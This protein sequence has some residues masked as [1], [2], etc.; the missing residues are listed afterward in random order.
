MVS[1][2]NF[3]SVV[4]IMGVL[5]FLFQ[6]SMVIRDSQSQYG[7]NTDYTQKQPDG[8][9]AWNGETM[10]MDSLTE[11][12]PDYVLYLGTA[13]G[14]MH[15]QVSSWCSYTKRNLICMQNVMDCPENPGKIPSIV[16]LESE[17][18]A[19]GDAL[20]RIESWEQQG[21][22]IIFGSLDDA[23]AIG[24]NDR[25]KALLGIQ[26]VRKNET[27]L[28]GVRLFPEFLLGGGT[29]YAASTKEEQRERQDMQLTVP[30][31][32]VGTG[33]K[34]YMTGIFEDKEMKDFGGSLENEELPALIW[35]NSP[36]KGFVFAVCG[37]YMKD[38]TAI[39]I[40]DGM[41]SDI[42][43]Y[44]LYPVVN[45]QNLSV[46]DF[47]EFANENDDAMQKN[48]SRSATVAERDIIWPAFVALADQSKMKITC[49]M[50][51]ELDYADD[52]DPQENQLVFYLKQMKEI[53]AEAGLALNSVTDISLA[54]KLAKDEKFWS[55]QKCDYRFGAAY[56]EFA[57][58]EDVVANQDTAPIA[59]VGTVTCEYTKNQPLV[60][61]CS[62]AV[63]LQMATSDGVDY[64]YRDDLRMRSV[65]SALAYTNVM[66]NMQKI[67]W[68]EH[69][70]DSWEIVQ[71]RFSSNL[72][73]FWKPFEA[74]S[75]TTLSE[76]D[77][78]TRSL[79]NMNYSDTRTENDITL[80]VSGVK[81][82]GWFILRT[83]GEEIDSMDGGNWTEIESGAY[84]IETT[85]E[86]AVIHM[87]KQGLHYYT[88]DQTKN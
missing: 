68:P 88:D 6:F 72:L 78:R 15:S 19:D 47:P 45:A 80:Q 63:T 35:R 83:H 23:L 21:T 25:L 37:D 31:Y 32:Q 74:F 7:V 49:F 55:K 3:V 43:S 27:E 64:T 75:A 9:N 34:V 44:N 60:S 66:L 4:I 18:L 73:T 58:I 85:G 2:R 67:L 79:L 41:I 40:L 87:K 22:T 86:Q 10:S 57:Q 29:D 24:Q 13:D 36:A 70:E 76:S 33:T 65:Q 12:S 8:I 46:V 53:N 54:D 28:Y 48:Y 30:W 39:G 26:T 5:L 42:S 77:Q 56:A 61:Y 71:E 11:E 38:C 81:D 17:K 69:E 59:D 50:T 62:D 16:I 82:T 52:N 1:K 20:D 84:L 14:E 51:P